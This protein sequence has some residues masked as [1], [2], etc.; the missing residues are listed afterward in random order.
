[1]KTKTFSSAA[2]TSTTFSPWFTYWCMPTASIWKACSRHLGAMPP[3]FAGGAR[4]QRAPTGLFNARIAKILG[5]SACSSGAES[6]GA[7]TSVLPS[8][9]STTPSAIFPCWWTDNPDPS[10]R[11]KNELGVKT[12]NRWREAFLGNFAARMHRCK[13][14]RQP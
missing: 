7:F 8:M 11:E 14:P 1:M 2:L 5:L 10:L 4:A 12:I 6:T 9:D 3:M 13:A